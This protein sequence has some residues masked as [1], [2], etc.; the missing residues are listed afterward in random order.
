MTEG[1]RGP[2]ADGEAEQHVRDIPPP[3]SS[4]FNATQSRRIRILRIHEL[5]ELHEPEA[6]I[7]GW[8]PR[9]A[10]V[11]LFGP[12]GVGKT[13]IALSMAT[14]IVT[15]R[16]WFGCDVQQG[17]VVY[18]LSEG[19]A[20]VSNRLR[21]H[22][23]VRDEEIVALLDKRLLVVPEAVAFAEGG[24]VELLDDLQGL[25]QRPVLIIVDTLARCF[26]SGDE[27]SSQDMQAFVAACD[28]LRN[29]FQAA[30]LVVHHAL[31]DGGRER[32]SSALRGAADVVLGARKAGESVALYCDKLRDGMLPQPLGFQIQRVP[33]PP[34]K[35]GSTES[36]RLVL[37]D[38][39]ETVDRFLRKAPASVRS[40]CVVL[41]NLNSPGGATAKELSSATALKPATVYDALSRA[42]AAS[43]VRGVRTGRAKR[44]VATDEL[45]RA[46]STS[47]TSFH[48]ADN[49]G[50]GPSSPPLSPSS[51]GRGEKSPPE[52]RDAKQD[53]S[54][55]T[56]A[57]DQDGEVT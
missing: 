24:D 25:G 43:C 45:R 22:L 37:E 9:H 34:T 15:G 16:T 31:R 30:V 17:T 47:S 54:Q 38:G 42:E 5:M 11:V 53:A 8:L 23:G 13:L 48:G 20:G 4:A 1:S 19:A 7:A 3:G 18:I 51:E 46:R 21:A 41:R 27:N 2:A 10:L 32:G 33:L 50:T 12:P 49:D 6:C 14:S 26:G 57:F 40:V 35:T 39:I 52:P 56:D 36:C 28:R 44:Y 55:V 29:T